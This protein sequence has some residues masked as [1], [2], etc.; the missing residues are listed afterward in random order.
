MTFVKKCSAKGRYNFSLSK[1]HYRREQAM[2]RIWLA[3]YPKGIPADVNV[4]EYGSVGE[5][6]DKSVAKFGPRAAY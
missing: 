4:A 6:F 5:M 1:K 2:E 3:R